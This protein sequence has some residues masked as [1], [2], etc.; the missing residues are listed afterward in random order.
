MALNVVNEI[1]S[2]LKFLC[3]RNSFLM[4]APR[5]L[6]CNALIQRHFDYP[7]STWHPNLTNKLKH[8]FKTT[9]KKKIYVFCLNYT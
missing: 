4:R 9:Q 8:K 1:N 2:K 5:C 7:C 6:L 3:R